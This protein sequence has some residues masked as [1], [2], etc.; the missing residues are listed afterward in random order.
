L[1][2]ESSGDAKKPFT[3]LLRSKEKWYEKENGRGLRREE[4]CVGL[5][6]NGRGLN[7]RFNLFQNRVGKKLF[8]LNPDEK[9]NNH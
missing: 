1:E 8:F 3:T 7:F 4:T 6:E 5:G 2:T 9:L